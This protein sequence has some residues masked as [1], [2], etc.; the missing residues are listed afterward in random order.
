MQVEEIQ[1]VQ[2]TVIGR[3]KLFEMEGEGVGHLV[4][5]AQGAVNLVLTTVG[6]IYWLE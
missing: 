1:I 5:S 4:S 6:P 3:W 2:V